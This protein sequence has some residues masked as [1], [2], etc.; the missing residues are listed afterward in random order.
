VNGQVG[1]ALEVKCDARHISID[2]R[3]RPAPWAATD[4]FWTQKQGRF[5]APRVR[6]EI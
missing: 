1:E 4:V 6:L 5:N 3:E 2:Y